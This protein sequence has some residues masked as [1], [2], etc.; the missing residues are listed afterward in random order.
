MARPV[1]GGRCRG[2][3]RRTQRSEI[4]GALPQRQSSI[5]SCVGN[6]R[7]QNGARVALTVWREPHAGGIWQRNP[8]H[9][10]TSVPNMSSLPSVSVG[11]E[12][13]TPL[14]ASPTRSRRCDP[15]AGVP[16]IADGTTEASVDQLRHIYWVREQNGRKV[17]ALS[18]ADRFAPPTCNRRR[19]NAPEVAAAYIFSTICSRMRDHAHYNTV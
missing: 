12:S 3:N 7:R 8:G 4:V 9:D 16:G 19:G 17:P 2:A 10:T 5:T 18:Q 1:D 6:N 13:V 11:S 15:E 14:F